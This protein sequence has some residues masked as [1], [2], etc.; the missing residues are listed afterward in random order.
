MSVVPD[1]RTFLDGRFRR[2]LPFVA[3]GTSPVAT[4][5]IG[6]C[7]GR[8]GFFGGVAGSVRICELVGEHGQRRA[9]DGATQHFD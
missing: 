8:P 1:L 5:L 2:V 9:N 4:V 7:L 6:L 3:P